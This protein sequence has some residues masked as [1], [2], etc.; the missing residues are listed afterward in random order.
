MP[1]SSLFGT[2]PRVLDDFGFIYCFIVV[3]HDHDALSCILFATYYIKN[4]FDDKEII[5]NYSDLNHMRNRTR[6]PIG[7]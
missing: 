4:F 1:K 3:V 5:Q 7:D 6:R 2:Q